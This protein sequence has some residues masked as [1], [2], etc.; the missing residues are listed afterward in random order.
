MAQTTI[1]DVLIIGSGPTGTTMALEL[2]AQGIPF[3]IVDKIAQRSDKS[4]ALAVQPRS[5][6]V[7][8]RHGP[9]ERLVERGNAGLG[10]AI[11]VNGKKTVDVDL[12]GIHA[13][14]DSAFPHTILAP[15]SLTEG[16]LAE[17]LAT[18]YGRFVEFGTE[19]TSV[20]QNADGVTVTLR[21]ESS[22]SAASS[23]T[24]V[25]DS[26][27][28]PIG[29]HEEET[30]R[31]KYVVGADGA[32]S[33]VR[34][35]AAVQFEGDAYPQDFILCDTHI[36]NTTMA[37]DRFRICMRYGLLVIF[38]LG[39]GV[40]RLVASRPGVPATDEPALKDFQDWLDYM[41]PGG[42]GGE[43]YDPIWLARFKLHHRVSTNYRDGRLFLAGDAA[44]IHSPAGG[45][46]MNTGI[47]DSANLGW[48]LA[49]VLR[50]EQPDAFLD[51]YNEERRPVGLRIL[52]SSDY[53][54]NVVTSQGWLWL[55]F[56]NLLAPWV[57]PWLIGDGA[58]R[59]RMFRFLSQL[60][61]RYRRS[62]IVGTAEGFA[63]PVL[64]GD[65][66]PDGPVVEFGEEKLQKKQRELRLHHLLV[67][68]KHHLLLFSGVTS[69]SGTVSREDLQQAAKT[70]QNDNPGG[71]ALVHVLIAGPS[72]CG[73]R[74]PS[75]N[76]DYYLDVDGVLHGRYGFG[77]GPGYV[78]VRPDGYV[79]HIGPLSAIQSFTKWL[80]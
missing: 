77:D 58:R 67:P 75:L 24:K 56:R 40:V 18:R 44:H 70:F 45:Q 10:G 60:G 14:R 41:V 8:G 78:Y 68:E 62:S 46:G 17:C 66:A 48:K 39:N 53:L 72:S 15:Q 13:T 42:A 27:A 19:A 61:V 23:P 64:G 35:A 31:A 34:H 11:F 57:L 37:R 59:N 21:T 65:R 69:S 43:L 12:G 1:T 3:R 50:G 4:K 22:S 5:L 33:I 71:A 76:G 79:A 74:P 73:G 20:V 47:Q 16:F 52:G 30:V 54:F 28:V 25:G 7:M 26:G 9:V 55:F 63:G 2:A 32:H 38:P 36:R 80:E 51:T 49:S 6:E 29:T